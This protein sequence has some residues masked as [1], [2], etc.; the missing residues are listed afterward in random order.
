MKL[1]A[2]DKYYY[3]HDALPKFDHL[4]NKIAIETVANDCARARSRKIFIGYSR[5]DLVRS[6]WACL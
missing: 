4:F 5:I 1:S 6:G 2:M 3:T